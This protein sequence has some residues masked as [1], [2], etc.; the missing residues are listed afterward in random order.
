MRVSPQRMPPRSSNNL[1]GETFNTSAA[2]ALH[3]AMASRH[4]SST[5]RPMRVV[6]RLA[7]VER[8]NNVTA[9]SEPTSLTFSSG[10]PI[11]SAAI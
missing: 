7:P 1:S 6:V 2:I 11:S 8:S 10:T 5:A 9:V 3:W 4:A